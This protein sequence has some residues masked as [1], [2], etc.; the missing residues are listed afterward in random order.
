MNKT[1]IIA[2]YGPAC[3]KSG[4]LGRLISAGVNVIRF[5]AS[6]ERHEDMQ[7]DIKKV[8]EAAD[9]LRRDVGIM[10][11]LQGPKLRIGDLP[12]NGIRLKK[13]ERISLILNADQTAAFKAVPLG[14]PELIEDLKVGHR[15]YLDDGIMELMVIEVKK[16]E[17]VCEITVG[18]TL[19]SRKG[20]NVPDTAVT[21]P[22]IMP[23]DVEDVKFSIGQGVDWLAIS[24]VR[25]PDEI[26]IVKKMI[27]DR[28]S[29][30]RVV[31]KIE[32]HEAVSA[33]DDI[34]EV[35]DAVMVARGDLGVELPTEEVPLLQKSIIEKCL[36]AGKPAIV[37]TQ[38][39]NSMI[40][41]PRPTRA[42]VSDVANAVF[43]S[44]DAVMLSGETSVGK[45]P[46][47]S[48]EMMARICQKAESFLNFT[49]MLDDRSQWAH[50]TIPEAVSFAACKIARDLNAR[51]IITATQSGLTARKISRYRPAQSVIACSQNQYVVN[52]LMLSWGVIPIKTEHV[53]NIDEMLDVSLNAALDK[54][55][56]SEGDVVVI[57]AGVMVNIPGS[58]NL[59]KV[60]QV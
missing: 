10:V 37:A 48:V 41:G 60:H 7:H 13:G 46:V 25:S 57:T 59:I 24:F 34:I 28:G 44:A 9:R 43:D 52:Q 26:N 16:E 14:N 1:K 4:V 39:L 27:A 33:I 3:G 30:I 19:R 22:T 15:I 36:K 49:R 17:V 35:T 5:N 18:G 40:L 42:E 6:H 8:R 45:Y 20:I 50:E 32:K 38:M 11:D 47:E 2:T 54:G 55:E 53:G 29:N 23:K 58:T 51:A 31:A 12:H 21:M 56:I